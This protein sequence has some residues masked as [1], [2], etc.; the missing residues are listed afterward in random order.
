MRFRSFGASI[1]LFEMGNF[2]DKSEIPVKLE[3]KEI[4]EKP[5]RRL[6][7]DSNDERSDGLS[8]R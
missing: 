6:E 3:I 7:R 2:L 1:A 5:P 8:S 4:V